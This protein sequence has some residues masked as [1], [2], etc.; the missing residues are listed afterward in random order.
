LGVPRAYAAQLDQVQTLLAPEHDVKDDG[1]NRVAAQDG[2]GLVPRG[3]GMH[4]IG[5]PEG[6]AQGLAD[7]GIVVHD[8][9]VRKRVTHGAHA[10]LSRPR[11]TGRPHLGE[12]RPDCALFLRRIQAPSD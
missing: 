9:D 10:P 12:R 1:G 6:G 4:R 5:V 2:A 8:Q 11:P 3:R 7:G